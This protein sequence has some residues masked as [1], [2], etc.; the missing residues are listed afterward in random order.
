VRIRSTDQGQLFFEKVLTID[1]I[2]TE[3]IFQNPDNP[4]D[5]DSDGFVGPLDVLNIIDILNSIGASIPVNQLPLDTPF[6]NVNGDKQVDPLDVLILINFINAG[7][8]NGGGEGEGASDFLAPVFVDNGVPK[9]KTLSSPQR[10]SEVVTS[11]NHL[12]NQD[13]SYFAT[14]RC[15]FKS[16]F[17]MAWNVIE[18]LDLDQDDDEHEVKKRLRLLRLDEYFAQFALTVDIPNRV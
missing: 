6:V 10:N 4:K 18:Q 2:N 15:L 3:D 13:W 5:V 1:V 16:G 17:V 9:L 12:I 8:G 7:G 11:V 14:S